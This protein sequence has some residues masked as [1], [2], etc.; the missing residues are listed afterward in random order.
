MIPTAAIVRIQS[1][2]WRGFQLW[3][4]LFLL[5]IPVLL[6]SPLILLVLFVCCIAGGIDFFA[7]LATFWGIL[8]GLRGTDVRVTSNDGHV[9]VRIL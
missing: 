9:T 6:L 8:A 4:P 7:A 2:H 1:P 5:W 3:L